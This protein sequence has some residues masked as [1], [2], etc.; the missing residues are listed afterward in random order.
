METTFSVTAHGSIDVANGA[1]FNGIVASEKLHLVWH[2]LASS[3]G[4]IYAVSKPDGS[5][6]ASEYEFDDAL[7]NC[8]AL[9]NYSTA[10]R[11][12]FFESQKI[13]KYGRMRSDRT[14]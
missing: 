10:L 13:R 9:C 14:A 12:E 7:T 11:K 8:I 3:N 1:D 2:R 4:T 5:C 6:L